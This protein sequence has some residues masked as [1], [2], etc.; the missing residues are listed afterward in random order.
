[1]RYLLHVEKAIARLGYVKPEYAHSLAILLEEFEGAHPQ[2][3]ARHF[4]QHG[5][6]LSAEEKRV[7]GFRANADLT[8]EAADALTLRG[9][10][11]PQKGLDV[12]L[13]DATFSYYRQ[14]GVTAA[15]AAGYDR[16]KIDGP[17]DCDGCRRLNKTIVTSEYLA[18]LPPPDC[19]RDACGIGMRLSIDYV[20]E[21]LDGLGE[22]GRAELADA[23]CAL[24]AISAAPSPRLRVSIK[25]YHSLGEPG[26]YHFD[27][28]FH[29][30]DCG[31]YLIKMPDNDEDQVLCTACGAPFGTAP[32]VREQCTSIAKR[33]MADNGL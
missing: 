1:M 24:E 31:G 25:D 21:L 10:L 32:E 3:V 27:F 30:S 2:Q 14:R 16:F 18:E 13:L 33:Y 20:G 28:E 5:T 22:R 17:F 26:R 8:A 6:P 4:R 23:Y 9:P 7:L 15:L 19:T 29:C 11:K 12:T